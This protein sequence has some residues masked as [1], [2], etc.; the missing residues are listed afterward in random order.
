MRNGLFGA[1]AALVA[2]ASFAAGQPSPV[3]LAPVSPKAPAAPVS[4]FGALTQVS[5]EPAPPPPAASPALPVTGL[6]TFD[7]PPPPPMPAEE[8]FH[9][10]QTAD[11][12][13]FYVWGEAEYLAW[14]I[15]KGSTPPPLVTTGPPT[16]NNPAALSDPTTVLLFRD[17]P[18]DYHAS[19][20]GRFAIGA[21]FDPDETF[22]AEYTAL[23]LV[24]RIASFSSFSDGAGTPVLGIPY[25]NAQNGEEEV[26]YASFPGRFA[27][28][29]SVVSTSRLWGMEGTFYENAGETT[30]HLGHGPW[31]WPLGDLRTHLLGG[32]RYLT[33]EE[34]VDLMQPSTV[35]AGGGADFKGAPL[36]TGDTETI[37]D[38]FGVRTQFFGGQVGIRSEFDH[39]PFY[40]EFTGKAA[41]GDSHELVRISGST[42]LLPAATG[43]PVVAPG[44]FLATSTNS[45]RHFR[46]Q[47]AFVPEGGINLGWQPIPLL[48]FYVGYTYLYWSNVLRAP[49]QIDR[50]VNLTQV[51]SS[52]TFGTLTGPAR[53]AVP[54]R[55]TDFHGQGMNFGVE[56]R[57]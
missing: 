30:L 26:N 8:R 50:T 33:L 12:Y 21:W 22:G 52:P 48:R 25:V 40:L 3:A 35:L 47:L 36:Q 43:I 32:F 51:P 29:I 54:F 13:P 5:S 23:V 46:D 11:A 49:D 38:F 37:H 55:T 39:G 7:A 6:A 15:K 16:A 24:Q 44:G 1:V 28:S 19:G 17:R 41:V 9:P 27:G 20:G 18:I 45:G 57:Y 56:L 4:P 31:P 2:C 42:T 14:G 53:P 10:T 34:A